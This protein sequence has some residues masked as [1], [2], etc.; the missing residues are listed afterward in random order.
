MRKNIKYLLAS[1]GILLGIAACQNYDYDVDT[2]FYDNVS[3]KVQGAVDDVLSINLYNTE[4]L[5]FKVTPAD[6]VFEMKAFTYAVSD[7]SILTIDE[8]GNITPLKEGTTDVDIVFRATDKVQTSCQIRI[9]RDIVL[10]TQIKFPE[11]VQNFDLKIGQSY[12][13][14]PS[15]VILP[16]DADNKTV[17]YESENTA[18]ATVVDGKVTGVGEGTVKIFVKSTDG[19]DITGY[20]TVNVVPEVKVTDI[21]L[22]SELTP[23]DAT[24][25]VAMGQ[26]IDLGSKISVLPETADNQEVTYEVVEGSAATIDDNGLIKTV[27]E[28]TVKIKVSANDGSGVFS[29]LT[30]IVDNSTWINRSFWT[31]NTSIVYSNGKNY[32]VDGTTGKPED[33]FD[34]KPATFLSLVKPGKSYSGNVTPA[35]HQLYFV[36]DMGIEQTFNSMQWAHRAGNSY[37]YLRV[38][39]VSL[40]GSNDGENFTPIGDGVIDIPYGSN[41]NPLDFDIPESTYRY[42]KV[43]IDKWSDNSGGAT[44]GSSVQMSEFNLGTK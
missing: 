1:V 22:P 37:N 36:V 7:E 13:I 21:V 2:S 8:S 40:Y 3:I 15:V 41:A 35:D 29:E 44:S 25:S 38:W 6:V 17:S 19:S 11:S 9:W 12:D 43:H 34:D 5:A 42:V 33:L 28:G 30:L 27:A 16:G 4:Q 32:V 39:G 14:S 10:V 24:L 18:I 31:V 26:N 20:C 23:E